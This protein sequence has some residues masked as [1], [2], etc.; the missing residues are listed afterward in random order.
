MAE[1]ATATESAGT[2]GQPAWDFVQAGGVLPGAVASAVG[3]V[4]GP[5]RSPVHR[6]LPSPYL[7]LIVTLNEPVV[8]GR[9][10]A[11]SLGAG[12]S[13]HDVLAAGLHTSPT[14][15]AQAAGQV[16]VQLTL[17]PLAARRILGAPAAELAERSFD[18][19]DVIGPQTEE[20]RE[21]L[22]GEPAWAQRIQAVRGFLLR[23]LAATE[24]LPRPRPE[25]AEA[26]R[27]LQARRGTG[28]IATLAEHV[29]LSPRRLR[30][31][32]TQELGIGPKRANRLIRFHRAM[33]MITENAAGADRLAQARIALECGYADEPHLIREFRALSGLSPTAWVAEER[34][35][36]AA[37]GHRTGDPPD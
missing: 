17:H 2:G 32:F 30:T 35:N 3:Y 21:R 10:A 22:A 14:F 11:E 34:A 16:G 5:Q 1:T 26:W 12:A 18:A 25:V 23:R 8:G 37:G 9:S 7:Q 15:I 20:L 13:R 24:D 4:A 27:W 29:H 28:R 33:R 36:I 19:A 6:G 31:L